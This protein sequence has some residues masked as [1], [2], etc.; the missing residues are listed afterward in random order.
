MDMGDYLLCS[1]TDCWPIQYHACSFY[2]VS[3]C[4]IACTGRLTIFCGTRL[5]SL[6]CKKRKEWHAHHC[7]AHLLPPIYSSTC[8]NARIYNNITHSYGARSLRHTI[9]LITAGGCDAQFAP[10]PSPTSIVNRDKRRLPAE[11]A[12]IRA[13]DL[14]LSTVL[15]ARS[16]LLCQLYQRTADDRTVTTD[17]ATTPPTRGTGVVRTAALV[18]T[19]GR[20][21]LLIPA[22]NL[23]S[24]GSRWHAACCAY[25]H[26][27]SVTPP[28]YLYAAY[29]TPLRLTPIQPN[30]NKHAENMVYRRKTWRRQARRA[31]LWAK[32]VAP[33]AA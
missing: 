22:R 15:D 28:V 13:C 17:D 18:A 7:P 23:R 31:L 27:P 32:R 16:C 19:G 24:R 11:Q 8:H 1:L 5:G 21:T 2:P 25:E 20:P 29:R 33:Y 9:T 4:C 6:V 26:G 30:R 12:V 10:V 14:F 3:R